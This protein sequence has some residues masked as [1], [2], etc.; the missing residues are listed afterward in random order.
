MNRMLLLGLL[1]MG[2]TTTDWKKEEATI[3]QVLADQEEAWNKGSL[4]DFMRGYWQSDSLM[5]IGSKVTQGWD[6]TLA[7]YKRNYPTPE[8]RGTLTFTILNVQ[9]LSSDACLVTGRFLLTR[10]NDAPTGLFTLVFRK[11]EE[12]WVIVYDHTS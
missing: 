4:E 5:F 6:S 12:H 10:A 7:R 9:F 11:K 8:A 1:L 3:R 2:C